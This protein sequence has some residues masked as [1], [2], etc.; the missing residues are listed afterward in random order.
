MLNASELLVRADDSLVTAKP[1]SKYRSRMMEYFQLE[2]AHRGAY[3]AG[4]VSPKQ[5]IATVAA[6]V[7][8]ALGHFDQFPKS[9]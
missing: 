6:A 7:D 1:E 5:R 9:T 3:V 4:T 2:G 8:K